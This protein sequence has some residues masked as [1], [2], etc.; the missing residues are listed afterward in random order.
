MSRI[1]KTVRRPPKAP[2]TQQLEKLHAHVRTVLRKLTA[3]RLKAGS[4]RR[5]EPDKRSMTCALHGLGL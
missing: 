2:V 1:A 4:R 3:E 5:S